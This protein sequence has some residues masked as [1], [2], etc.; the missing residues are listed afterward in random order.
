M[1]HSGIYQGTVRHR[2]YQP[3]NHHLQYPV[4][5]MYLDLDE[6]DKVL[7]LTPLWSTSRWAPA[8]FKR[9]D[10][11]GPA[12]VPLKEAVLRH[13][14]TETGLRPKGAVRMLTNLRYFGFIINPITCYYCFDCS[15]CLTHIVAEVT[16]T[17]WA[18]RYAYV[19][20]CEPNKN[21]QRIQFQKA[22]HVSPFNPMSMK[23][24]WRSRLPEEKLFIHLENWQKISKADEGC[25]NNAEESISG[26][27]VT[28]KD[29][30]IMDAS[31][32]L[33]RQ[34][35][36]ARSLKCVLARYPLMTLKILWLIYWNALKLFIKKVP[37]Y[38]HSK[39]MKR[40]DGEKILRAK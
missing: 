6:I 21:L 30:L 2:R 37:F 11:L 39:G 5:M 24:H 38:S 3:R 8:R 36:S 29:S 23:Y 12:D 18:E 13:V 9:E 25:T 26:N 4:F 34:D 15:E 40:G 14:E 27:S 1:L 19:L 7:S 22:M 32:N 17:P 28:G 35:I 10:Y 31:L 33:C 20:N 16:S